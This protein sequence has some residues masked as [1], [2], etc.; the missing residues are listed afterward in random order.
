MSAAG[1]PGGRGNPAG[2]AYNC[3]RVAVRRGRRAG[4][5]TLALPGEVTCQ[6][7]PM[8]TPIQLCEQMLPGV[9][10]TFALLIPE[11]PGPLRDEVGCAYLLCRI[12]DTV[13]DVEH[14]PI[15]H[16]LR[17]FDA[18]AA[19][20]HETPRERRLRELA[21]LTSGWALDADHRRLMDEAAAVFAAFDSFPEAD[22][23][24]IRECVLEMI[25]GM[26]QTV[27]GGSSDAGPMSLGGMDDLE[28]YC[29]YVAGV[30]GRM[31]TR[32]Y[33]RHVY[34]GAAEP[35]A[36]L[37]EQGIEFGLGLQMTNV[38][39]DQRADLNRGVSYMPRDLAAALGVDADSLLDGVMPA[40][41]RHWLVAYALK[42]LDA[43]FRY[44]ITWPPGATGIRTFCLGALFMAVRTLGVVVAAPARLD[45]TEAP[46][47]TRSDVDEIMARSR[48][49]A[50][51]DVALRAWYDEERAR[52]CRLL[53]PLADAGP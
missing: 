31:L 3:R 37:I 51:N 21:S 53:P 40:T 29:Y 47:I 7:A 10:R 36:S 45:A 25:G 49:D 14:V 19:A 41:M 27:C 48:C 26:R 30:V 39:K 11:L 35:P 18:L 9:S 42:W 4:R 43:A 52:L 24:V 16:R 38:L 33:W 8:C 13:E 22:R 34:G 1:Y 46:K 23:A 17:A 44:A 12:A 28:R 20:F 50:G 15:E 2:A 32:L 5:S 6:R